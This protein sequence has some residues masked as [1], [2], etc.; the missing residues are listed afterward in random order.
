MAQAPVRVGV[1]P[2][3]GQGTRFL[4]ATKTVPKEMLPLLDRPCLDY[5]VAE[6]VAA[7]IEEI[8]LV[9]AR[10]KGAIA[11]YFDRSP[12]LEASLEERGKLD[13]L[14]T[15]RAAASMAKVVTV[16]QQVPLGLGHAVLAAEA[17]VGEAVS[18]SDAELW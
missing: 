17:A 1:I 16:R 10:G 5:I 11:D 8:V 18:M 4:P 6:A 14:A 12:D 15:V 3:A 9:T 13:L 2:V 7:G